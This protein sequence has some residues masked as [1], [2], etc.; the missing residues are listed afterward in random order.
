MKKS[1][2]TALSVLVIALMLGYLVGGVASSVEAKNAPAYLKELSE[3]FV[4]V[5]EKVR[6]AV[7]NIKSSKKM[8]RS[9][10]GQDEDLPPFFRHPFREL[11]PDLPFKFKELPRKRFPGGLGSGVI[12]S[13]DGYILTNS[14][15]VNGA[16]EIKVTLSDNRTFSAKVKGMDEESDVAVI[17]ID[18]DNLPTAQLGDSEKL[19]VGEV[20]LAIGN[21]FGFDQT[22]TSG[23]VSAK[24]RTN[25]GILTYED[26]IQTDAAINPGNSGGPL[27]NI[28]GQ[29]VG[30]NTAIASRTGGYQGVGFA[31]PSNTAKLVMDSLLSDG[32]MRRGWLG[33]GIQNLNEELAKALGMD[34][35]KGALV[36]KVLDSPAEKAGIKDG[37]VILKLDG[38]EVADAS[39]LTNMVGKVK[40]GSKATLTIFRGGKTFDVSVVLGERDSKKL[41]SMERGWQGPDQEG[42]KSS[43]LGIEVRSVPRSLAESF[44]LKEGQGVMVV[45]VAPDSQAASSGLRKG[46]VILEVNHEPV[47]GAS[48]F[49]TLVSAAAKKGKP[50]LLKVQSKRGGTHYLAVPVG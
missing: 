13:P 26:F 6:P 29:V 5:S 39:A 50:V 15:V 40:P 30:I 33:V 37:D 3:A 17:K 22:V 45:D 47:S 16:D 25:V 11:F 44:G 42:E 49:E 32:K 12:V 8:A 38:K 4:S 28:E 9:M 31:I 35:P 24:G 21:P 14:H 36:S 1:V 48:S 20:V 43:E 34:T 19:R 2:S 27:V 18:A 41:P 23:I 46:D 7:V 10:P